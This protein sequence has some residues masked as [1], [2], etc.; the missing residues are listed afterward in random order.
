[1]P[2]N[3]KVINNTITND[4]VSNV[5]GNGTLGYQAGVSDVG[6]DDKIINNTISGVGYTPNNLTTFAIDADTSFT[7][8][9]KVH[10]NK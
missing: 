1:M 2:T 4:A 5:S 8:R 3:I 10:A 7:N 6:N 9:P